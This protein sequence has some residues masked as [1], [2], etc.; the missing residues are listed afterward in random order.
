[1]KLE[2]AKT[3]ILVVLIGISIL[4]TYSIW[5]YR[6]DYEYLYD[7]AYVSEVDMDIGGS[8]ESK[9]TLVKPESLVF[10][11]HDAHYRFA[12]LDRE[13]TLYEEMQSWTL[14]DLTVSA[15]NGVPSDNIQVEFIFP[16][17]LPMELLPSLFSFNEEPA[18]PSWS[19]RHMYV[20]FNQDERNLELVFLSVDG[21]EQAKAYV[22]D[23][24]IYRR[25]WAEA[26]DHQEM[27]KLIQ[28]EGAKRP[29]YIPEEKVQMTKWSFS[30]RL[31]DP[32]LLVNALFDNPSLVTR[33]LLQ[34][35]ADDSY[36]TDSQHGM[37]VDR[38]RTSMEFFNPYE[39]D[40]APMDSIKLLENSIANINE[41][42][43]WTGDYKLVSINHT[44]NRV[45]YQMHYNGFP[46]FDGGGLTTI[47]QEW[48]D[49]DLY[50]YKRPLVSIN[51][52]I[53]AD[54][55]MVASGQDI[56]YAIENDKQF[57]FEMEHVENIQLG[58]RLSLDDSSHIVTL[59]PAWYVKYRDKWHEID[60][61]HEHLLSAKGGQ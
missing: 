29:I 48:R 3:F 6:P 25:L 33:N 26:T 7:R 23:A 17:D 43:G 13:N 12:D 61:D 56:V 20:T 32:N 55:M 1:M 14:N 27:T 59:S 34:D 9:K 28:I 52:Q 45:R 2:T 57:H 44:M 15:S 60:V 40:F 51:N 18:L 24:D 10:H 54:E 4:L 36:Y 38:H 50:Q 53:N 11:I 31:I 19:F 8:E 21:R 37:R 5:S 30:A 41:H 16:E 35:E 39:A 58:Y 22:N 49:N 46:V 42:N 47:E